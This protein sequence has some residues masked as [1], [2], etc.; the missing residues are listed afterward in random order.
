MRP[1][2]I[3]LGDITAD[4]E[5]VSPANHDQILNVGFLNKDME[6]I[7]SYLEKFEVIITGDGPMVPV[8]AIIDQI[9]GKDT[10]PEFP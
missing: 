3:L 1:N 2:V 4:C 9:L 8:N 6:K 5:M 7:D 10:N